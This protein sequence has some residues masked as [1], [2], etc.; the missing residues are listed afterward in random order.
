MPDSRSPDA[1]IRLQVFLAHAG[2]AS[3]RAS[4]ALIASGRVTVDGAVVMAAGTT[5]LPDAVVCVDGKRVLRE[6]AKQYVLLNK[7]AGY[8]CSLADDKGRPTA[9]DIL[10]TRYAERLYNIGRLDMMSQGLIIFTN[11]GDFAALLSHPSAELEKEYIVET[12]TVLPRSLA[13]DF[14]NGVRVDGV[15]YRC[16]TA[17]D[18]GARRMRIVL[19]EGKNREIR[20]VFASRKIG[21]RRLT[22]VR[23]G[24]ITI[25]GLGAGQFR[26]LAPREVAGL[27]SLCKRL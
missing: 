19:T 9:A 20:R 6:A 22:R 16:R 18:M 1:A 5:V 12:T 24:Q 13:G 26:N 4:E 15:F 23:I 27:I 11:D 8:V 21:I 2:V 3:R 25:A 10:K 14:Q 7:P 17:E